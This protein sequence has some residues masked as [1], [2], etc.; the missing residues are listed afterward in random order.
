MVSIHERPAD[1]LTR[2]LPKPLFRIRFPRQPAATWRADAREGD[3]VKG[4]GNAS[5]I[6]TLVEHFQAK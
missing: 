2:L 5:A 4:A 6:G 3:F 1:A